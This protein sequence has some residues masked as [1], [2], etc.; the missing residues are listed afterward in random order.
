MKQDKPKCVAKHSKSVQ[1]T[2]G[3][4]S[5]CRCGYSADGIFCDG[6]HKS[7]TIVPKRMFIDSPT[8]LQVCLCKH[9]KSFPYCD[10]SHRQL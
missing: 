1:L 10:G 2:P 3:K 5:F 7:T 6:A 4:Y 8:T 9:S